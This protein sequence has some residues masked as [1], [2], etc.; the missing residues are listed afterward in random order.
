MY[1]MTDDTAGIA[2]MTTAP[3]GTDVEDQSATQA[4]KALV[5]EIIKKIK[6]DKRHHK[7]AFDR[8]R[9]DMQVATWGADKTWG[10][11]NYRANIIGRHVKMKTA[12]LYAKNPKAIAK[13][14]DTLDFQVWDESEGSLQLAFQTVQM[15]T[16]ALTQAGAAPGMPPQLPPGVAEAQA[17]LANFQEGMARRKMLTRYGKTLEGVFAYY[18]SE[19]KPQDFKRGMKQL[20]RRACTTSVGYVEL[21]FQRETGPRPGLSESA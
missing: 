14:R 18:M 11:D 21:G 20:V 13:R 4:D 8:M 3:A 7:K 5:A 17:V 16:T 19:Q 15:A 2:D 6:H 12:A 9:R 10:E 1:D